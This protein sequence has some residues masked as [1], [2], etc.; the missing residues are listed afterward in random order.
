M[1]DEDNSTNIRV[2]VTG[3][4][5]GNREYASG[6]LLYEEIRELGADEFLQ[7]LGRPEF[8]EKERVLFCSGES[9]VDWERYGT[10]T[11]IHANGTMI[12]SKE[13][14]YVITDMEQVLHEHV[15]E[16]NVCKICK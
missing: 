5:H 14:T 1:F 6:Y 9:E 3:D 12:N 13:I 4:C 7:R 11:N 16:S 8:R 15:A 2:F 10:I